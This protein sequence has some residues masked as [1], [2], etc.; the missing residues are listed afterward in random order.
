M[1]RIAKADVNRALDHVA[2]QLKV[3]GGEDGRISRSDVKKALPTLTTAEKK[4]ADIFFKFVDH[5][6]FKAGATVTAKDINKA[7]AYAKQ[8]LIAKYDL[9]TNGLSKAE[10]SEMSLT[11]QRAVDLAK[12]LKAAG[13]A[14]GAD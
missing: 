6:D 10:I 3:A 11:G 8:S 1:A 14:A 12:A 13:V 9:N 7:V 5:R 2:K 4:L